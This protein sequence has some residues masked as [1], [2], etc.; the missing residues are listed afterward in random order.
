MCSILM[1]YI[2]AKILHVQAFFACRWI[3]NCWPRGW[4]CSER[5][6]LDEILWDTSRMT[7]CSSLRRVH[8]LH[9][10]SIST[11]RISSAF[12]QPWR[13]T[14]N[15]LLYSKKK[16]EIMRTSSHLRAALCHVCCCSVENMLAPFQKP[17]TKQL[18]FERK[19]QLPIWP[20]RV[21]QAGFLL[22]L[23]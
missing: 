8:C 17:R 19:V 1:V 21:F 3:L 10:K 2:C 14:A 11:F 23:A 13:R 20:T 5:E 15:P 4:G 12:M 7:F 6:V 18:L 22:L 16:S 9:W